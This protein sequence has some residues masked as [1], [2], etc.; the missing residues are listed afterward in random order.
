MQAQPPIHPPIGGLD[1]P[2]FSLT[3]YYKLKLTFIH[4]KKM[5]AKYL[6][7]AEQLEQDLDCGRYAVDEQL[8]SER[9]LAQDHSLSHMTVNKAVASLVARGRLARRGR[10]GTVVLSPP[11]RTMGGRPQ[12]SDFVTVMLDADPANHNPWLNL[13][14]SALH[15]RHLLPVILD[16][17]VSHPKDLT[18]QQ[19]EKLHG[20]RAV[21]AH[22][23]RQFPYGALT[24]MDPDTRLVFISKPDEIPDHPYATVIPDVCEGARQAMHALAAAGRLTVLAVVHGARASEHSRLLHAGLDLAEK[25]I[26][27]LKLLRLP[28]GDATT[29]EGYREDIGRLTKW[30]VAGGYRPDGL[31]SFGDYHV[32]QALKTFLAI[33]MRVPQDVAV[34]GYHD[35][36][37][38]EMYDLTTL[39]TNPKA[40]V[41]A[42]ME[43]VLGRQGGERLIPP[44]LVW[45]R[46]CPRKAQ[47]TE[48]EGASSDAV[49]ISSLTRKEVAV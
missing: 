34:V 13:L 1:N 30:L 45:R 38:A 3:L 11:A 10:N 42:V 14:P 4:K 40:V 44:R 5:A 17:D 43:M 33:G 25:E 19:L 36:P 31:F 8:P 35:T 29:P 20:A 21:I 48:S 23:T 15:A 2:F 28:P 41:T 39:S 24:G 16:V 49:S 12:Q 47:R 27:G 6:Q 32:I 46:S 26:P 9:T 37:W 22:A 7:F 18:S